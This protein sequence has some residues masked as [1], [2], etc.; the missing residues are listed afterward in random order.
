MKINL[1]GDLSNHAAE[2]CLATRESHLFS[3]SEMVGAIVDRLSMTTSGLSSE[4]N[5]EYFKRFSH[6]K[7][8]CEKASLC[9]VRAD[10]IAE[11]HAK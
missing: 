11:L 7:E 5:S 10:Q 1:S 6:D 8:V 3:S 9:W 4:I 2:F